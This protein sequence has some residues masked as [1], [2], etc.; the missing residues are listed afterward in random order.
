MS[1]VPTV[2]LVVDHTAEKTKALLRTENLDDAVQYFIAHPD[3][4]GLGTV[5]I[6]EWAV[7]IK[8]NLLK[9]VNRFDASGEWWP[10]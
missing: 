3:L 1:A 8:G 9:C 6:E 5:D 7:D 4:V 10:D 2:F